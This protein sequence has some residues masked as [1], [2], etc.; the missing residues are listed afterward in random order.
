MK[1]FSKITMA[2]LGGLLVVAPA[3]MA[4]TTLRLSTYGG[5]QNVWASQSANFP[6]L[7]TTR[8]ERGCRCHARRR[9]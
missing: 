7:H 1:K 4:Q 8:L 2:L 6:L 3:A 9:F 5:C